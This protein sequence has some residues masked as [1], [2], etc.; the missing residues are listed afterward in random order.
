MHDHPRPHGFGGLSPNGKA[1]TAAED[2]PGD[3]RPQFV[4]SKLKTV[5]VGT[6]YGSADDFVAHGLAHFDG[7][8]GRRL[9][10]VAR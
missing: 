10:Q 7:L 6:R 1:D 5:N 9:H 3:N 4:A 8:R 2:A